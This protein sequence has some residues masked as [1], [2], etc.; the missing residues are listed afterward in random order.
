MGSL[1]TSLTEAPIDNGN[2]KFRVS[3]SGF[4]FQISKFAFQISIVEKGGCVPLRT[5]TSEEQTLIHIVNPRVYALEIPS[6]FALFISVY[7][8]PM[9]VPYCPSLL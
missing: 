2:S 8:T 4:A 7:C 1:T 3:I 9:W 6:A 5:V